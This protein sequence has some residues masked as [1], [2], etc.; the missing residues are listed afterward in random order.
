LGVWSG[1]QNAGEVR[2]RAEGQQICDSIN[3]LARVLSEQKS[4]A[5]VSAPRRAGCVPRGS[6]KQNVA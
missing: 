6:C 5:A 2:A 3:A 1:E 4:A